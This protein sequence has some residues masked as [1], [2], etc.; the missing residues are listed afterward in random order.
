MLMKKLLILA[1]MF[2]ASATAFA[3]DSDALKAI[4]KA[5]TY[6]EAENLLKTTLGQLAN[7]EEK[8]EAYNKLVS[9]AMDAFDEQDK[10]RLTN[11]TLGKNDPVDTKAMYEAAYNALT[12]A[13]E[14]DKYDQ[15]PNAKGKIKPRFHDKNLSRL[16]AARLA[17]INAGV[18]A[19]NSQDNVNGYKYFRMYLTSA[20]SPL[21]AGSDQIKNDAN[22]GLASYYAGRCA[23][24]NEDYGAAADALNVALNDT[25]AE[26]RNGAFDFKLY[27]MNRSQ[28][29]AA[30][31]A[32]FLNDMKEL[33]KQYPN[34]EKVFGSLGDALLSQEKTA[35]LIALCDANPQLPLAGIYKG[36]VAMNDKKYDEAIAAFSNISPDHGSYLQV[37]YNRAICKL[38]KAGDFQDS[39]ANKNTGAM[40]PADEATLKQL[41]NDARADFEKARELDPDQQNVR[42]AALLRNIYYNLGEEEKYKELENM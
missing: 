9:L 14:C 6:A 40:T 17:V 3:G 15:L 7:D 42:W 29:T 12:N 38:N 35:E 4:L 10:V 32:K 39:H 23:I 26:I 28:K 24:L 37:V 5:K 13:M 41:L 36:M 16:A 34:N 31:S 21:F 19:A 18:E 33:F 11:Q 30:D 25:N 27:A 2:V 8:A 20:E 1:I 22:L